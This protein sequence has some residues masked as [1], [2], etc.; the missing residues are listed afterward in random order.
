MLT[1]LTM[2][3]PEEQPTMP[4]WPPRG[5][6]SPRL[7]WLP[8]G[9]HRYLGAPQ[10]VRRLGLRLGATAAAGAAGVA[11]NAPALGAA[12]WPHGRLQ[13]GDHCVTW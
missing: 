12:G 10:Q 4:T 2:N 11:P 8:T 5:H 3:Q 13:R 1:L 7:P 9:G 6:T